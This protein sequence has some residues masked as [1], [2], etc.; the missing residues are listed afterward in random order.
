MKIQEYKMKLFNKKSAIATV[1]GTVLAS[2]L[3]ASVAQAQESR[4]PRGGGERSA[5][6]LFE[7]L[8]SSE[9]GVVT[10]DEFTAKTETRAERRF[11]R[12][13]A[14]DDGFISLEEATTNRR[15]EAREDL[16]DLADDIIACVTDLAAEDDNIVVP[17]ADNFASPEER[18]N[19]VDT[20]GDG[21]L[22]LEEVQASAMDKATAAFDNMDS[23]ASG[24]VTLEEFQAAG[25]KRRA[26][27]Q[28][29]RSCIEELDTDDV[30]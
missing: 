6:R 4:G 23:D 1:V 21:V 27:R 18:F 29:I 14:D 25:E 8:D 11:N 20:S 2:V 3:A 7:R 13:D 28:A 22:S 12:K 24:D 19:A 9:D 17:D 30:I 15:G 26:T 10:L 16:S 5:E